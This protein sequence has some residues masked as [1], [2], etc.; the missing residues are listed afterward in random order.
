MAVRAPSDSGSPI[1]VH[2]HLRWSG[3]WQRPQQTHSRLA[4]R[5]PVTFVEEPIEGDGAPRL[6]IA[7]TD[8]GV[9]VV[10]PHLARSRK[11][12]ERAREAAVADMLRAAG[13]GCLADRLRDAVHWLYTPQME[14]HVDAVGS[15]AAIVYDCMDE[16]SQFLHAP[17]DLA[18][19][20]RRLLARADVVFTG[21]PALYE[22]K[23]ALHDNTHL[24]PC[25]VDFEHF[26][27]AASGRVAPP[28]DLRALPAPR[29]GYVGAIDERLDYELIGEI[30]GAHPD[31]SLVLIG[32]IVKV[33][34][35]VLPRRPNVHVLG[36]RPYAELPAYIAGFDVCLMPFALNRATDFIN[37]TK[38][39][40][41]LASGKPVASTPIRDV[42]RHFSDVVDVAPR[43]RWIA[44]L[45]ALVGGGAA[46]DAAAG[47]E[48]ARR[49]SWDTTVARMESLVDE[50]VSDR[51]QRRKAETSV[52]TGRA[53]ASWP[54]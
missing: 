15:P 35:A 28:D 46:R 20:E 50:A 39:L 29:L 25:G 16:L 31:W 52:S 38:T 40:E 49:A 48:R 21:G 26:N 30:A 44:T 34:P 51:W 27:A 33:D 9:V 14:P 43:D 37:P 36:P 32:P 19:R 8:D 12:G 22:A 11:G 10:R 24:F 4:R 2:C 18:A 6:D 1:V 17:R 54:A 23:C 42:A 13:R 45:E 5:R 53:T 3:I 47:L 41:Y 7:P